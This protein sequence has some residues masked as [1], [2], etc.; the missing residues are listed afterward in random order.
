[1][2]F[3][4]T[5]RTWETYIQKIQS[6]PQT[7]LNLKEIVK[8][9]FDRFCQENYKRSMDEV[10]QEMKQAE[11]DSVFD[12]LQEWINW[13][14]LPQSIRT[15]FAYLNPYFYYRGIKITTLDIKM[16]LNFGRVHEEEL[17]G[18]SDEEY[19]MIL[20][21]ASFDYKALFLLMGSS[22]MRPIE[23]INITKN[24]VEFDKERWI[25]HVPARWTKKKRAKTTFCSI[26]AMKFLK[27]ILRGKNDTETWFNVHSTT[28]VDITFKRYCERVGLTKKYGTGRQQINPMSF[29]AW[30]RTKMDRHDPNL[31]MKWA[32]QKYK[33]P[34]YDR[35]TVEEQLQK[36]MDFELDLLVYNTEKK[37]REIKNLREANEELKKVREDVDFLMKGEK[38][39]NKLSV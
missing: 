18:L 23:A 31:S 9:N 11:E 14:D 39:R 7:T 20:E 29:R 36:Y 24:D 3:L 12:L 21:K 33:N 1:V 10:I 16:N 25:I 30:F 8:N 6:Y 26:E 32:G 19:R 4:K 38:L 22:G 35:M 13:N 15:Y 2:T 5:I 17:H 37:D 27:P 34:T 28:G